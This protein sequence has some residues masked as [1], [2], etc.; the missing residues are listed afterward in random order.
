MSDTRILISLGATFIG[1]WAGFLSYVLYHMSF[2]S[3]RGE[4]LAMFFLPGLFIVLS[5]AP[6]FL[7]VIR[8]LPPGH[9]YLR[10]KTF[11]FI[12][13]ALGLAVFLTA[14]GWA[15]P[16]FVLHVYYPLYA[17]VAGGAAAAVY[18]FANRALLRKAQAQEA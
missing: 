14:F 8:L 12:G 16:G 4:L 13:A 18:A 7:P 3:E 9:R 10:P 17:T 2:S 11:P 15:W 5:W 1:W 6:V